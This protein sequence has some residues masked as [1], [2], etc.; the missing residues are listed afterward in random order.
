MATLKRKRETVVDFGG[1]AAH[2]LESSE[3]IAETA[4]EVATTAGGAAAWF[5]ELAASLRCQQVPILYPK[6]PCQP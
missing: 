4:T 2:V 3:I 5:F 1:S 6:A